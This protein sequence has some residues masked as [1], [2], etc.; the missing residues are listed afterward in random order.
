MISWGERIGLFLY[1]TSLDHSWQ[2]CYQ[3]YKQYTDTYRKC[4]MLSLLWRAV[5]GLSD[6]FCQCSGD[7]IEVGGGHIWQRWLDPGQISS[8]ITK[9]CGQKECWSLG[10]SLGD[11]QLPV[12]WF[13]RL[14]L[15]GK[16]KMKLC[17]M[18]MRGP[19]SLTHIR[20]KCQC[21]LPNCQKWIHG[22]TCW[23]WRLFLGYLGLRMKHCYLV[24]L[25]CLVWWS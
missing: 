3:I 23:N 8:D 2:Q 9:E 11:W 18:S 1:L 13:S 12:C 14:W 16:G 5:I 24:A 22:G 19:K 15:F 20:P 10:Y 7:L 6:W 21:L 17:L 25:C 4:Q